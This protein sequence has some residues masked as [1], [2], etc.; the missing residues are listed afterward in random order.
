MPE[1][2]AG[3]FYD[4]DIAYYRSVYSELPDNA[5][6]LEVGCW[7]GRSICSV[8][9]LILKKNIFC[10]VV[11]TFLGAEN[12]RDTFCSE[13]KTTSIEAI[14]RK[15]IED[16]GITKQVKILKADSREV[17]KLYPTTDNI[18]DFIFIDGQ[19]TTDLV[20]HDIRCCLPKLKP[21][22]LLAGHDL[23]LTEVKKG[24]E[25]ALGSNYF[26][27]TEDFNIWATKKGEGMS[28]R[29]IILMS[30]WSKPCRDGKWNAK[31]PSKEWWTKV[32]K[33]LKDEG[34]DV[35]Q[36]GQGPEIK[37]KFV[38]RYL[39]DKDLWALGEDIK[40]CNAWISVDN[41]FH[42]WACLQFK[43]SGIVIWSQSDPDI[44]GHP[45]NV[46]LLKDKKF[47]RA[48]Q[49]AQWEEAVY[50]ASAFIF[51]ETVVEKVKEF[52]KNN[53]NTK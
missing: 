4:S 49:F 10:Y 28:E 14:F 37:L 12:E 17:W 51:P 25:N 52:I 36:C 20:E 11:D 26:S 53:E 33:F 6:T 2:P 23:L 34:F 22:C 39:W 27:P 19:H 1:L 47:L 48:R 31:S 45:E 18:F 5:L 50:D 3:W 24:V 30:C 43:K 13:A 7:K 38:D 15:N 21:G 32:A 29:K 16:F 41:F 44:F 40:I 35:W 8:A 42:H 9:D 46:N